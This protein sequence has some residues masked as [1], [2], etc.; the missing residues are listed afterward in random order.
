[1]EELNRWRS[2]TPGSSDSEHIF[3]RRN[4]LS[5]ERPR[6]LT[7]PIT[8]EPELPIERMPD[9][10]NPTNDHPAV[11]H[12][13]ANGKGDRCRAPKDFDG[14]KTKYKTW[15]RLLEAY[16]EAYPHLY[17]NDNARIRFALT[18]MTSG[19][20][21]NW[22][23]H[24]TDTHMKTDE[25][26]KRYFDT[27]MKWADFVLLLNR[28][29]DVRR[30]RDKAKMDLAVLNINQEIS[31]SIFLISTQWPTERNTSYQTIWKI[32]YSPYYSFKD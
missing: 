8:D 15:F 21:A 19:R 7:L 2:T 31:N 17:L 11:T 6:S 29:F 32:Q 1:M 4:T 16:M 23:E 28:T 13:E 22:A 10:T 30:T 20:A 9:E 24:F 26:R 3:S 12:A 27:D 14:D 25:N 18:Y 5:P